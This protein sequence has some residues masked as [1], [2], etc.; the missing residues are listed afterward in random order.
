MIIVQ[1][2]GGLGNQLFQYAFGR[3]LA[4]K[5]NTE[6]KLDL[7]KMQGRE[8]S[9]HDH[10]KLNYFNVQENFA[11]PEEIAKMQLIEEFPVNGIPGSFIPNIF[12]VGDNK[13]LFGNWHSEKYFVDIADIIRSEF[14]L[15]KPLEKNSAA[16]REKILSAECAVSVH[17]RHGDYLTCYSRNT[18][19]V[20]PIRYYQVCIEELQKNFPNLTVF[21]FSDDL[22]WC[23]E[24]LK[25][26]VPTEFVEGCEHSFEELYL[27][28]LCKHNIIAN[29]TFAW[30]GAWLNK[31]PN[32]KVFAPYTWHR[33]G[34]AGETVFTEGW[35]KIPVEYSLSLPPM[36]SII[37]YVNN[38][39]PK[40]S[41]TLQSILVLFFRN[42]EI[43]LLDASTD[44]S[45]KFCRQVAAMNN[46]NLLTIDPDT[47]K[48]EAWNK[49]LDIAR[50]D[51]V[52]FFTGEDIIFT[53]ILKSISDAIDT[54][55]HD[56]YLTFSTYDKFF[57][58][59]ICSSQNLME[60]ADGN[61]AINELPDKKF[62]L[63]V[64]AALKDLPHMAEV[65]IPADQK[66]IALATKGINNFLS[67]KFFKRKFLV[68]NQ[69]KFKEKAGGGMDAELL[70]LVE[71]FLATEKITFVP[72]P[73]GGRL[74]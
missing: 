44:D 24:N 36:V 2:A 23:K 42:Y 54:N 29:S 11:T 14:T 18:R 64:D 72:Q 7:T 5:Y 27:M 15:K 73:F 10:Y 53:H 74:K 43:I 55:I 20:L 30:W 71:A 17:V 61:F 51:Y 28:S 12:E 3:C 68:E 37:V 34:F 19:G 22:E 38:C 21:I 48:F 58:N 16:W 70:F 26:D 4:Y 65:N 1:I 67:T 8:N 40:L 46:V 52:L 33:G 13:L 69:I 9:H 59:I 63:N 39:L 62:S 56:N 60:D 25:F 49:G 45:R 31:N 57:P 50:G 32:K 6:L 35:I 41:V 66:L 47:S